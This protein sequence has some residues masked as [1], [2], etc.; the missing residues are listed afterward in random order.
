MIVSR[1]L[2]ALQLGFCGGFS[3]DWQCSMSS[4]YHQHPRKRDISRP[5]GPPE[6]PVSGRARHKPG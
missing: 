3:F 2:E 1:L 5:P 6:L 4:H